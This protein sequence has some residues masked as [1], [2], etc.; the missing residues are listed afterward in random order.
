MTSVRS[1]AAFVA[2]RVGGTL[3]PADPPVTKVTHCGLQSCAADFVRG[4]RTACMARYNLLCVG[5]GLAFME[6]TWFGLCAVGLLFLL[7]RVAPPVGSDKL[8]PQPSVSADESLATSTLSPWGDGQ[9][10]GRSFVIDWV[11]DNGGG[12]L[13]FAVATG[14]FMLF[15]DVHVGRACGYHGAISCRGIQDTG[16]DVSVVAALVDIM[17]NGKHCVS[18]LFTVNTYDH[19]RTNELIQV[20]RGSIFSMGSRSPKRGG[21]SLPPAAALVGRGSAM[22]KTG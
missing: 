19:D 6:A 7:C 14:I 21:G 20:R 4:L 13:T 10:L 22:E 2:L 18:E 16:C 17:D 5:D 15:L 8:R 9:A 1:G 11:L 12:S 3:P